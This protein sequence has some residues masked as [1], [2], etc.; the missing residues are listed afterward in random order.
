MVLW[1]GV[2]MWTVRKFVELM[3]GEMMEDSEA[4]MYSRTLFLVLICAFLAAVVVVMPLR[5]PALVVS[6]STAWFVGAVPIIIWASVVRVTRTVYICIA[7]VLGAGLVLVA[8]TFSLMNGEFYV[9]M[10]FSKIGVQKTRI[11][12]LNDELEDLLRVKASSSSVE[13][14]VEILSEATREL[15]KQEAQLE[16]Q[17]IKQMDQSSKFT[18]P[19]LIPKNSQGQPPVSEG[20]QRRSL[21]S[22]VSSGGQEGNESDTICSD[23]RMMQF[24]SANFVRQRNRGGMLRP[25]RVALS[26]TSK[27]SLQPVTLIREATTKVEMDAAIGMVLQPFETNLPISLGTVRSCRNFGTLPIP[28]GDEDKAHDGEEEVQ[29]EVQ[30]AGGST[31][32][33]GPSVRPH[34][35]RGGEWNLDPAVLEG[36]EIVLTYQMVG[37]EGQSPVSP[38]RQTQTP[39][40]FSV[41]SGDDLLVGGAIPLVGLQLLRPFIVDPL[42]QTGLYRALNF[43]LLSKLDPEDRKIARSGIIDLILD[44]DMKKH[45]E[46]VAAM[47]LRLNDSEFVSSLCGETWASP[48]SSEKKLEVME[49]DVWMVTRACLKAADLGHSTKPWPVHFARSLAVTEEFFKQGDK[50]KALSLPISPLCDR[51]ASSPSALCKSQ[52]GFLNFVCRELFIELA[53]VEKLAGLSPASRG[54]TDLQIGRQDSIMVGPG[55]ISSV[56]LGN[57]DENVEKWKLPETASEIPLSLFEK[58]QSPTH[59]ED[60]SLPQRNRAQRRELTLEPLLLFSPSQRPASRVQTNGMNFKDLFSPKKQSQPAKEELGESKKEAENEAMRSRF[61]LKDPTPKDDGKRK[62]ITECD[63]PKPFGD[64]ERQS[65]CDRDASPVSFFSD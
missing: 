24:L 20:G 16:S 15:R 7:S 12:R 41:G 62:S 50:E 59:A 42:G 53:Q 23:E 36:Q 17:A 55:K 1:S 58:P 4:H 63:P 34:R 33:R 32:Q 5:R 8:V 6:L 13:R 29:G 44:T 22:L 30:A 43:L 39:G 61:A 54:G 52:I 26:P 64:E 48:S 49:Q 45:F 2:S 27:G 14:V 65:D 56:C 46:F 10:M 38:A 25:R 40:D 51:H 31:T 19:Q 35:S 3:A 21:L 28:R 11:E 57:L 9:R 47:K 37:L 60:S 18:S